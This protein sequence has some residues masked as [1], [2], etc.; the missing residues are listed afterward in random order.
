MRPDP[1][2][3]VKP[4][5]PVYLIGSAAGIMIAIF[6]GLMIAS[7]LRG[8]RIYQ[9]GWY[10]GDVGRHLSPLETFGAGT[11]IFLAGFAIWM[12]ARRFRMR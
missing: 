12:F 8:G 10:L 2:E 4:D 1:L 11:G 7:A 3:R 5:N 9:S 6:G